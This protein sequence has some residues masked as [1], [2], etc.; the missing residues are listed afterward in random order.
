M[1]AGRIGESGALGSTHRIR[2]GYQSP[3][4][5][6]QQ[7]QGTI[8]STEPR[9][10]PEGARSVRV[11]LLPIL[12][13]GLTVAQNHTRPRRLAKLDQPEPGQE[14]AAES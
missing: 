7:Q 5:A 12:V 3:R 9:H 6:L 8:G 14:E 4:V 13:L 1:F 2:E 11:V 10:R